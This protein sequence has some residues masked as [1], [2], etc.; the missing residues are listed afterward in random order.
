MSKWCMI[1][2]VATCHNCNNCFVTTKDEHVDNDHGDYA[3]AQPLHGHRW[4]DIHVKE[5][6]Q[7]PMVEANYLPVM[8][9]Q[10]DHAP[11]V[12][13]A[14]SSGA[15]YKREDG[16]VII[17][18]TKAKGKK[19]IVASCPYGHIWWNEES[20][21]PQKWIFDAHLLDAGWDK[22]RCVQACP[23]G[24][25]LSLKISD[26][27]LAEKIKN[28][29][30]EPLHP[31]YGTKPRIY[32]KNL[33]LIN[34]LFVGGTVVATRGGIEDCIKGAKVTLLT[35]KPQPKTVETDTYGDFKVDRIKPDQTAISLRIT[36]PE[37]ED[38]EIDMTIEDSTYLGPIDIG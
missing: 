33:H 19:E 5:R 15:V 4:I 16:I 11:C 14:G 36:H 26:Q 32:Y 28:E 23:T 9:N 34:K 17:S 3:A 7:A 37:F 31:E 13:A 24:T 27:E 22:P 30:L 10:C 20:E 35:G 12:E 1:I 25:L 21:L 29:G 2:D 8:C 18:P 38:K 6:G